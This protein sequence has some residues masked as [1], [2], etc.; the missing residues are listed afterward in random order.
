MKAYFLQRFLAYLIDV[1]LIVLVVSLIVAFFPQNDNLDKLN[2]EM[3]NLT[4]Q[5]LNREV[6]AREYLVKSSDINYDIAYQQV[7]TTILN[8]SAFI[9]YFI[10]FQYYNKG[11][12]VGKK[13]LK[14]RTTRVD[15]KELQMNDL[16]LRSLIIHSILVDMTL[17]AITLF[18]NKEIYFYSS[19]I[20]EVV[21]SILLIVALVMVIF[22]KDGRG[23]HDLIG[24]TIVVMDNTKKELV[25]C[26]EN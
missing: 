6:D 4:E 20:L 18:A 1:I 5:Y 7:F 11:Q 19:N 16:A 13:L 21:Q 9:L 12:T 22:R 15:G 26:E 14:I 2:Q 17:L 25:V 23:L 24:N 10:V 3:K 8:I